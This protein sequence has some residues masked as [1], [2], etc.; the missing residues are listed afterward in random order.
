MT[1]KIGSVVLTKDNDANGLIPF[2][3]SVDDP[4]SFAHKFFF[5]IV[6]GRKMV[7]QRSSCLHPKNCDCVSYMG[8]GILLDVIKLRI[9]G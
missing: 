2:S 6:I 7:P 3:N 8:R 1:G 4:V 5:A 9:L